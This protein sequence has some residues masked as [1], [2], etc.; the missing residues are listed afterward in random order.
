MRRP[1]FVLVH[2]AWPGQ[3]FSAC[4]RT[5]RVM[6]RTRADRSEVRQSRQPMSYRSDTR[7]FNLTRHSEHQPNSVS[8]FSSGTSRHS[9]DIR[10]HQKFM[11]GHAPVRSSDWEVEFPSGDV[12]SDVVH[13]GSPVFLPSASGGSARWAL[14]EIRLSV[15]LR[16]SSLGA[17]RDLA[18]DL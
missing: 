1:A 4:L 2:R 9:Q 7:P 18:D 16:A 12:W 8:G 3:V 17:A 11:I 14:P 10:D 6:L 13:L 15:Q 5:E